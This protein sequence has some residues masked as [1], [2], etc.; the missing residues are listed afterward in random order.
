MSWRR[1]NRKPTVDRGDKPKIAF[2]AQQR[3]PPGGR[4]PIER[5]NDISIFGGIVDH[6]HSSALRGGGENTVDAGQCFLSS[7]I[8][9]DE[10]IDWRCARQR[11]KPHALRLSAIP[12]PTRQSDRF[13]ALESQRAFQQERRVRQ[14]LPTPIGQ[15]ARDAYAG[16]SQTGLS[17]IDLERPAKP[18]MSRGLGSHPMGV[19]ILIL[20]AELNRLSGQPTHS[21]PTRDLIAVALGT[22]IQREFQRY[23]AAASQEGDTVSGQVQD[24]FGSRVRYSEAKYNSFVSTPGIGRNRKRGVAEPDLQAI[25]GRCR[26]FAVEFK[27]RSQPNP[28]GGAYARSL[29]GRR[30]FPGEKAIGSE[31]VIPQ[32]EIQVPGGVVGSQ[33]THVRTYRERRNIGVRCGHLL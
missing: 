5:R 20:E 11:G 28:P 32:G 24:R 19:S 16:A 14:W 33:R 25:D 8:Y 12:A 7:A 23:S 22:P 17:K 4:E 3:N 31:T 9:R 15:L 29:E 13:Q 21:R 30:G 26:Q 1:L 27:R 6:D 2:I 10:D 18:W